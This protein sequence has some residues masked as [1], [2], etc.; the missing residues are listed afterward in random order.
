M[1]DPKSP[2]YALLRESCGAWLRSRANRLGFE[3]DEE[4]LAVDGYQRHSE[5]NGQLRFS[6]VDFSG[7]LTVVDPTAFNS[8]LSEGVGHAKAFGCGLLSVRLAG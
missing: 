6:P 1:S 7:E 8:A 5:K 2:L 4:S 3:V